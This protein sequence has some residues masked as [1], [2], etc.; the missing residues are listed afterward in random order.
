LGLTVRTGLRSGTTV[1]ISPER[2]NQLTSQILRICDKWSM[3][4]AAAA[5]LAGRLWPIRQSR[6]LLPPPP[7]Q[8]PKWPP[9]HHEAPGSPHL[10]RH[11]LRPPLVAG[12]PT[13]H[14][15]QSQIRRTG[16]QPTCGPMGS[17]TWR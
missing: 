15:V 5:Q 4:P 7:L 2:A 12:A 14:P 16:K 13:A 17:G 3:T 1:A 9:R 10:C 8:V 11:C 6:T